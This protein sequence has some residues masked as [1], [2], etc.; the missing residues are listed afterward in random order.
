MASKGDG[1]KAIWLTEFGC[2]T[3]TDGGLT[4]YC[5]DSTLAEQIT[6]AFNQARTMPWIGPL[7][8]YNWID[9][10]SDDFGLYYSDATP[11][12]AALAAFVQA[13]VTDKEPARDDFAPA[14]PR[15]NRN[16]LR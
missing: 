4:A 12:T 15:R 10:S 2:P 14:G 3:G 7:M 16:P 6:E 5:T 8:I 9:T 13:L 1:S 11:K